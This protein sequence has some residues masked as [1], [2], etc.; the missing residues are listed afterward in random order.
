MEQSV[1]KQFTSE[2][3]NKILT[4]YQLDSNFKKLGDFENYAFEVYQN[5]ETKILRV[6]HSSHRSQKELESEL[7]WI[8]YLHGCGISIPAVFLSPNGKTVEAVEAEDSTFYA[9]LFEKAPGNPVKIDDF[10]KKLFRIWGKV[11]G[12]MHRF[13]KEYQ[14]GANIQPR[15]H[16][17]ENDLVQLQ[18]YY[19][20]EDK[21]ALDAASKVLAEIEKLPKTKDSYGLL[22]TDIHSGNFF[23][24][25]ESIHIFDFDDA[26]Y[27][28]FAS[29]IAIPLYYATNSKHYYDSKEERNEFAK[30]FIKAFLEGYREENELPQEC[31]ETIPLFLKLRDVEL[32]AVFCKKVPVEERNERLQHWI[33][34]IKERIEKNEAIVDLDVSMNQI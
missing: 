31:L 9:S 18:Y 27:H 5:G 20:E 26:S 7:D 25:G 8:Q 17:N 15:S 10:S 28:Y 34:E 32:Y 4:T 13:T 16:W 30:G 11:T 29:D 24:D 33:D 12:K 2:I 6:T 23:Y 21:K 3:M 22:H 19:P 14:P 1:E